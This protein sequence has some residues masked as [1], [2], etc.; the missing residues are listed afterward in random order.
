MAGAKLALDVRNLLAAACDSL[1]LPRDGTVE[2]VRHMSPLRTGHV[3]GETVYEIELLNQVAK[4]LE[5]ARRH[6][7]EDDIVCA[8]PLKKDLAQFL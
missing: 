7:L 6:R 1:A 4:A 2:A 5:I 3:F 8:G